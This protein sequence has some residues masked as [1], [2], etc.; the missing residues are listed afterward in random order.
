MPHA[1]Q[2]LIARAALAVA[3]VAF[4]GMLAVTCARLEPA[5]AH[6]ATPIPTAP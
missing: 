5:D 6:D 1:V 2:I 3:V 4:I